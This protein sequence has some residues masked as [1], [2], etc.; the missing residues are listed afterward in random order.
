M[1]PHLITTEEVTVAGRPMGSHIDEE[2]L[3]AY[4]T[5]TEMMYV[6]PILG[7]SLFH[8]MLA[9]EEDS[10]EKFVKLLS[11]GTYGVG[12]EVYSFAGLKK[13]IAYYVF[14]K[15]IMVG[16]FQSTR[17]GIV[18][19]E[20]DYSSHISSAERS[21]CYNDALEIANVYMKDCVEYCNRMGLLSNGVGRPSASGSVKIRKIG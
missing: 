15:N 7:D 6:K 1:K 4:I 3:L 13:A 2:R 20:S 16:D 8:A 18:M 10:N 14:A 9:D 19:K 11:G 17:Y 5:E 12:G 21:S